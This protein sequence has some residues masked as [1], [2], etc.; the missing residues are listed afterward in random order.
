MC[1]QIKLTFNFTVVW[2][3]LYESNLYLIL[4]LFE[5]YANDTDILDYKKETMQFLSDNHMPT[6][7]IGTFTTF[8]DNTP[9]LKFSYHV[10]IACIFRKYLSK[11]SEGNK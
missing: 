8:Q 10:N 9:E 3:I 1:E 11:Q 7:N 5:V 6:G 2:F 4:T